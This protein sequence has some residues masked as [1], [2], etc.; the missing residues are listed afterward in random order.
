MKR[1]YWRPRQV[2]QAVIIF[3]A[4]FSLMG[5]AC[6]EYFKT[7]KP[8]SDLEEKF[9]AAQ[10]SAEMMTAIKIEKLNRSIPMD[11]DA[12]PAESGMMGSLMSPITTLT[13]RLT[14]KQTSVNPNFAAVLVEMLIEAGVEAGDIVAVGYSGSFPAMNVNLCA[15]LT[16]LKARPISIASGGSSQWGANNPKFMWIDMEQVLHDEGLMPFHS[17][18]CSIGGYEDIGLGMS[19]EARGMVEK[20]IERNGLRLLKAGDFATAIDERVKIY[21]QNAGR[22]PIKC[23]VNVGGGTISVGRGAGKRAYKPGLNVS[24]SRGTMDIDSV[25]TRFMRKGVP[26]IHVIEIDSLARRYGLPLAP[27]QMPSEG[28]GGIYNQ[29]QYNKLLTFGVLITILVSLRA[30]VL[31]DFGHRFVKGR[32]PRKAGGQPEPMV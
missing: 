28:E 26:V 11:R 19:N 18:A 25:M 8:Q 24:A 4:V 2:S 22:E 29:T 6:V 21:E 16:T 10:L 32:G 12:D 30:F 5:L 27:Q 14:A 7:K 15:A 17:V 20:A 1:L 13:G 31:T 9:Q 23:Y 3:L